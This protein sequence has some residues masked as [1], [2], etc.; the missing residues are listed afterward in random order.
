MP[1]G[2]LSLLSC[3]CRFCHAAG[4]HSARLLGRPSDRRGASSEGGSEGAASSLFWLAAGGV[5]SGSAAVGSIFGASP[6]SDGAPRPWPA[7]RQQAAPRQGAPPQPWAR[8]LRAQELPRPLPAL[9][10][11][12]RPGC[13]SAAAPAL[14]PQ[15]ARLSRRSGTSAARRFGDRR[16]LLGHRIERLR[17]DHAIDAG[18]TTGDADHHVFVRVGGDEIADEAARGRNILVRPAVF[19]NRIE[20]LLAA[21][22]CGG[23]F[24]PLVSAV[25][26]CR[27]RPGL[28]LRRPR[29]SGNNQCGTDVAAESAMMLA[30][31]MLN[32][33][34]TRPFNAE[35]NWDECYKTALTNGLWRQPNDVAPRR[36]LRRAGVRTR[37]VVAATR[38]SSARCPF[39]RRHDDVRR[40]RLRTAAET[41][42]G[43]SAVAPVYRL[44]RGRSSW[45][46]YWPSSARDA[47]SFDGF[48]A[49]RA[50]RREL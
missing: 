7:L 3:S 21:R 14:Q 16:L 48:F 23:F 43:R 6:P 24:W 42:R 1:G 12:H 18:H 10:V 17:V 50:M 36:C 28:P 22:C 2:T 9:P 35:Q 13:A 20:L 45:S 38:R 30:A 11:P 49:T 29:R 34:M 26:V 19:G 41:R 5:C 15:T 33:R 25:G 27:R 4:S 37:I 8:L 47:P 40:N 44:G 39:A 31:S 46:S 32:R